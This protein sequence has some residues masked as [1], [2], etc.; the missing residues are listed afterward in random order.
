MRRRATSL[1]ET[2][3]Y[4]AVLA[5]IVGVLMN[6]MVDFMRRQ[7]KITAITDT[8]QG[9]RFAMDKITSVIRSAKTATAPAVGASGS[10]LSVNATDIANSPIVFA[11]SGGVITMKVGTG[12]ATA[13]T[14]TDIRVTSLVFRNLLDPNADVST[15][16]TPIACPPNQHKQLVCHYGNTT[17]VNQTALSAHL[18]HGDK[19]GSCFTVTSARASVRVEMAVSTN[20]SVGATNDFQSSFT[21]YDTATIRRQN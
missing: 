2:I 3:I 8:E 15:D 9:A 6:F 11:L 5:G 10:T 14:G 1:I 7:T 18:G 4:V 17:C 19:L 21:L 20:S 16:P 13:I 12:T